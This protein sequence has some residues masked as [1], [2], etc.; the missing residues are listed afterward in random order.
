[1]KENKIKLNAY[2]SSDIKDY[3]DEQCDF[4][5]MSLGAY[6]SMLVVNYRQQ[7]Q[8]MN[9]L[10]EFKDLVNQVKLIQDKEENKKNK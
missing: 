6:V 5:G 7:T 9:Q 2:V 8:A 4:Y 10:S 3:I 1:M